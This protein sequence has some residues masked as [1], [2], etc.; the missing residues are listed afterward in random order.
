MLSTQWYL[1]V[2]A[3]IFVMSQALL[4]WDHSCLSS[5]LLLLYLSCPVSYRTWFG[6][7]CIVI[8]R[9]PAQALPRAWHQGLSCPPQSLPGC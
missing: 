5:L 6:N 8:K 2:V 7:I 3:M 4:S 9:L 1:Y